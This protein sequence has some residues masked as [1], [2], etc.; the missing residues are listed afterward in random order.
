MS[1]GIDQGCPLSGIA[2]QF[3]NAGLV[4]KCDISRVEDAVAF[5]DNMQLLAWAKMLGE[6]NS[7]VKQLMVRSGGSLKWSAT[8]KSDFSL[9]KFV[10]MGLTRRREQNPSGSP[11]TRPVQRHPIFP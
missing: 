2:Y 7:K 4:D 10:I 11:K 5:M 8:H 9:E 6:S 3:Y 1:K